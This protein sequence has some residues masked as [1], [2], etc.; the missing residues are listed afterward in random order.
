[1]TALRGLRYARFCGGNLFF[2]DGAFVIGQARDIISDFR[3]NLCAAA[4]SPL[5]HL[6]QSVPVQG[7]QVEDDVLGGR[8][9]G[10]FGPG[11]DVRE[12]EAGGFG[13]HAAEDGGERGGE[14]EQAA[15]A[16]QG[17]RV[18][19]FDEAQRR[20]AGDAEAVFRRGAG[21]G[22]DRVW[23][24]ARVGGVGEGVEPGARRRATGRSHW[25]IPVA[26]GR[27]GRTGCGGRS[28]R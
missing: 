26:G 20:G 12:G 8:G 3:I 17:Q 1:M 10:A 18:A 4:F 6:Q 25:Q 19:G 5:N 16:G 9:G 27:A 7:L 2:E 15:V 22:L 21:Q 28:R 13:R 24:P 23:R 14:G 11:D